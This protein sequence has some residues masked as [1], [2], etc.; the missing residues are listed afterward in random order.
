MM[1]K[2]TTKGRKQNVLMAINGQLNRIETQIK[3]Q[4]VCMDEQIELIRE[5]ATRGAIKRGYVAGAISGSITAGLVST[6]VIL[7]RAQMGL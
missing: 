5:E 2:R 6:A 4:K 1:K 7:V 3:Q